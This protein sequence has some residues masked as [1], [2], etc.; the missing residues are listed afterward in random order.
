MKVITFETIDSTNSYIKKNYTDLTHFT[1][2]KS[3]VQTLGRGRSAKVWFGDHESLLATLLLKE[4]ISIDYLPRYALLAVSI[5]H[6][7]LSR[8]S[9][10]IE[11]KWPNDLIIGRHKLAGI[12]IE[13]VIESSSVKALMIGFGINLNHSIFNSDLKDIATS[14]KIATHHTY[15]KMQILEEIDKEFHLS[16]PLFYED[17]DSVI[18]YC[19]KHHLLTNKI[20]SFNHLDRI[21]EGKVKEINSLGELVIEV[22]NEMISINCGSITIK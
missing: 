14:L 6:K 17:P 10:S 8:Y 21:T 18:K 16:L 19:N 13:S 3:E 15:D 11:I 5:L 12:L 4:N 20:I 2:V 9:D 1:W 7:V 22:K